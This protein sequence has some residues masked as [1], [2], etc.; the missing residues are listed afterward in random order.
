MLPET[1]S[2]PGS[3]PIPEPA[4]APAESRGGASG[5]VAGVAAL[6]VG[7]F[8]LLLA[9]FPARNADLWGHL[10]AG[11]DLL[12][13][14]FSPGWLYDLGTYAVYSLA[15][16]VGLVGAKAL[17]V[18]ALAGVL[19]HAA[20]AGRGWWL[21]VVCVGLAVLTMGP[22]PLQPATASCL[23]L[24]LTVWLLR[25]DHRAAE[26]A[27]FWPDWRL[28]VLFLVW[29]NVDGGFLYGL[30]LVG[31]TRFGR[32][33]D[34]W[35]PPLG[36]RLGSFAVL[37]AVCVLNPTHVRA[38]AP[39]GDVLPA[40]REAVRPAAPRP[41][42]M[43][44]DAAYWW[45]VVQSPVR[46]AFFALL[47]LGAVSFAAVGRRGWRWDRFLPWAGLF[48]AALVSPLAVPFFAVVA[49]PVTAWNL[50]DYFAGRPA[51]R[52]GRG[53]RILLGLV[54]GLVA[55]AFLAAAWVGLL[56][57]RGYEPLEPRRWAVEEPSGLKQAAAAV[58][59][60]G[61]EGLWPAGTRTLHLPNDT[62]ASDTAGAFAWYA[63]ADPR[64]VDPGL[65][66]HLVTAEDPSARLR[67]AGVSR[68][69]VW[70]ADRGLPERV[71][72]RLLAD[73]DQWP[74]LNAA[75][76]V[77]VFGWR[78]PAA[79]GDPY[80]GRAV[81]FERPG[82][83]PTEAEAAP[84]ARPAERRWTEAFWKPAP[85][86]S[87]DRDEA[88][89]L[90]QQ[91]EAR[92]RGGPVRK[93][94]AWEVT[95]AAGLVAGA[96]AW[97]WPQALPDAAARLALLRP[98]VDVGTADGQPA[99]VAA[100][101]LQFRR[102]FEVMRDDV[103]PAVLYAAVRAARRAV[104]ADPNDAAAHVT[105][106]EAYLGLLV[107]T[108]ERVW[109]AR[110]PQLGRLREI[111]ALTAFAKAAALNP[112]LPLAHRELGRLYQL[113][114]FACADLALDHLRT[115]REQVGR[116][117]P[118][119]PRE[120]LDQQI[121]QLTDLVDRQVR[122]WQAETGRSSVGARAESASRRGLGGK[123]LQTLLESDVSAFG[124]DGVRL[125]LD[126]WLR[127]GR[128]GEFLDKVDA[129]LRPT[130]GPLNFHWLRAQAFVAVGEYGAA[131]AELLE[132]AVLEGGS[133]DPAQVTKVVQQS[134]GQAV[135]NCHPARG[136]LP[137]L[138][139]RQLGWATF[140]SELAQVSRA[141][142]H[143][144]DSVTLRGVVA[145][146][147]GDTARARAAFESALAYSDGR[148]G[149]LDFAARPIAREGLGWLT[150][151]ADRR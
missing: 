86:R 92:R 111:Q 101:G 48:G 32:A 43:V 50:Q 84:D 17:A 51:R 44:F 28:L 130:L 55:V 54:G 107:Q 90:L 26:P 9:S 29:A 65:A 5:R 95:E 30:W 70:A 140:E 100:V 4:A 69:V 3:Q 64:L 52:I 147:A 58:T 133:P 74:L 18:A 41:G 35:G 88:A 77:A 59:G 34:G 27:G 60:W 56:Q 127:A 89:L 47:G 83:R 102:D 121:A 66:E 148:T 91:G 57:R 128:A 135:L 6:F 53:G 20:R 61:G 93:L 11:R 149:G 42:G 104:A 96:A 2:P 115:Y 138:M 21:P 137:G 151:P 124:D 145:L 109:A 46:L 106:G 143:H 38:F 117:M 24:A 49:G 82:F 15:G 125:Q 99:P 119:E 16:G 14:V 120:R 110:L 108:R 134:L 72:A 31:L 123:A 12:A 103:P 113:P 45:A 63:P 67:E 87:A 22:R 79:A 126:L 118:P 146:E 116:R 132:L 105:L 85:G 7:L 98:P 13:G 139:V 25:D 23:F 129:E 1:L 150:G 136:G 37:V 33:L 76:G 19:L 112:D 71:L 142:S 81:D 141:L 80:R 78:D 114:G 68:V 94:V 144:A 62:G 40:I 39:L 97:G 122:E 10:A 36:S 8:A 131:D 73:P 75:G